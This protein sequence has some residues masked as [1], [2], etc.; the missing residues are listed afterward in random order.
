MLVCVYT[1]GDEVE[2]LAEDDVLRVLVEVGG[3]QLDAARL[4]RD[5]RLEVEPARDVGSGG[6]GDHEKGRQAGARPVN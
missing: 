3:H 1:R 5:R 2:E 6:D 4:V